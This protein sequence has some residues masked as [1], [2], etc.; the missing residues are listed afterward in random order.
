[1]Y[2]LSLHDALPIY[3][4]EDGAHLWALPDDVVET[5][6][7]AQFA[8]QVSR[9]V[10]PFQTFGHFA[11]G[12]AQLIDECVAFDHVTVSPRVDRGDS[13]FERGD[14]GH[15]EEE[16]AWSDF[17]GEFKEFHSSRARHAD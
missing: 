13:G 9:L 3:Q 7:P 1:V 15:Q 12:A 2:I 4:V 8:P 17:F 11:N 14:S 16:G 6:Q 5:S 10:L